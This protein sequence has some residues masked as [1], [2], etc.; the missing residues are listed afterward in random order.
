M[1]NKIILL[2]LSIH[3]KSINQQTN[4]TMNTINVSTQNILNVP[5]MN[6]K[7]YNQGDTDYTIYNY[8][9]KDE[10]KT[11]QGNGNS[12]G[13][14][15]N[16]VQS[17][18]FVEDLCKLMDDDEDFS[19][20]IN[21]YGAQGRILKPT[22]DFF[23]QLPSL[24]LERDTCEPNCCKIAKLC[25]DKDISVSD[26]VVI[27]KTD[28]RYH[29]LKNYRS[30]ITCNDSIVA[31]A[32]SKSF[33]IES[34]KIGDTNSLF[35]FTQQIY[36]NEVI[37][38][39]MINLFYNKFINSW[40]IATKSAIGGNYWYYRTQ[41]DGSSEFDKQMTFRQ[42]FMEALGEE[43][44]SNLNDS[45]VVSKCN[46]DFNYSFVLQH[47]NNHIVINIEKPTLYLVAGFKIERDTITSYSL[48]DM[49]L[50]AFEYGSIDN[51]P[52][53]L[54]CIVDI[55]GKNVQDICNYSEK[56]NTGIMI[57]NRIN[58]N[59]V[60]IPNVSYERVKDIRGNNQNIHY[61]YLSLFETGKVNEFLFEFPMY[62]R[63]FYQFYR[64]SYDLIKEIHNAYV[65]YYVKK[66]G[67][68]IRI[69]KSI[70]THIY[71]LHN[72]Y[73]IPTIDSGHP[74]IV[75]RDIVSKY[76]NAMTP[77][78][79]LYHVSYKTREYANALKQS[80]N[81]KGNDVASASC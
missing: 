5:E 38:G 11:T 57:H 7:V 77:K 58:G 13:G 6:K 51:L 80:N 9:K 1:K 79:K 53:L 70:F 55:N 44:N 18:T 60:K 3:N 36:A 74:T 73:Y 10:E 41:Y 25:K 4:T 66:M 50:N 23:L 54:P 29:G 62:K 31:I 37:E 67:K 64:Q 59:R 45:R 42:M 34:F 19:K 22:C 56:Y 30:I 76:Y 16:G 46:V 2:M 20:W 27:Y 21:N 65:S 12:N 14:G 43:S 52:I 47:P 72:T 32:P 75:T 40:E 61:H 71:N 49:V 24:K 35:D 63:L 69:S 28:A 78:E 8:K 48:G 68:S 33:P 81:N 39:T 26:L 15:L 17:E